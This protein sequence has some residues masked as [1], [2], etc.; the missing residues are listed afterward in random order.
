MS[1]MK[2]CR[3]LEVYIHSFLT[4]KLDGSQWV[5]SK[6]RSFCPEGTTT[7]VNNREQHEWNP[8]RD[9]RLWGR[10]HFQESNSIPHYISAGS[11]VTAADLQL[12]KKC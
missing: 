11:T 5:N 7:G 3:A 8:N 4:S 12:T 10:E 2:A 1:V 9:W 6:A